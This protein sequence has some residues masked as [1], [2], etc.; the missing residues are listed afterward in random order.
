[1]GKMRRL[2]YDSLFVMLML[3]CTVLSGCDWAN[4]YLN[5]LDNEKP[6]EYVLVS[7]MNGLKIEYEYPEKTYHKDYK[8]LFDYVGKKI[9]IIIDDDGNP[10]RADF[11]ISIMGFLF[12]VSLLC[13]IAG[14]GLTYEQI[15][16]IQYKRKLI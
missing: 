15:M 10:I 2:L 11:P 1:M 5:Y 16:V 3:F 6:S 12:V 4:E 13:T 8:Y 14:T 7:D 9:R